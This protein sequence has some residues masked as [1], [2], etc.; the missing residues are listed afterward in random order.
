MRMCCKEK[1]WSKLDL[2]GL[3]KLGHLMRLS[4]FIIIQGYDC[5]TSH[6][7][8]PR[9]LDKDILEI[10]LRMHW[11]RLG[12]IEQPV[13]NRL[14]FVILTKNILINCSLYIYCL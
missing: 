1:G 3:A 2:T 10:M 5:I 11:D 7:L 9:L 4:A 13:T 8:I 6:E 12:M 14:V